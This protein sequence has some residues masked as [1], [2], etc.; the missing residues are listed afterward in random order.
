MVAGVMLILGVFTRQAAGALV[1][2]LVV[3]AAAILIV[4]VKGLVIDCGCFSPE[5]GSTVGPFLL[6]RNLLLLLACVIIM[7]YD[8]GFLSL[9]RLLPARS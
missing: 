7:R 1:L 4:M 9:G 6:I 8:Q 3:F 2:L 5:G